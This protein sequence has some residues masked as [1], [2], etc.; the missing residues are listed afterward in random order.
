EPQARRHRVVV[1]AGRDQRADQRDAGDGVGRA[2]ERRVQERRHLGDHL[3]ADE[4]R[5]DEDVETGG[6][7]TGGCAHE[8][9]SLG[10]LRALAATSAA[11]SCTIWPSWVTS[12]PRTISSPRSSFKALSL[13][14]CPMSFSRFRPNIWLACVD[15]CDGKLSAPMIFT[16]CSTTRW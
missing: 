14:K 4:H 13:S 15:I 2:H 10:S 7:E 8:R 12:M 9:A 11:R 3:V 5:E 16:P 1:A 6:E